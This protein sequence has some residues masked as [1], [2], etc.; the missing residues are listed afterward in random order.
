M[1]SMEKSRLDKKILLELIKDS[2]QSL[3][4]IARKAGTTRQTVA[5]KIKQLKES[6]AVGPP[7]PRLD[8]EKFGLTT[9]A[10]IFL[11]EDPRGEL[12]KKDEEAIKKFYQ[13]SEFYRLFGRYSAVLEVWVKDSKELTSLVKRIHKLKGVR[14]TETFIVHSTVKNE[15]EAPFVGILKSR[16]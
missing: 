3:S 1:L 12:R 6:E 4:E 8:P 7:T 14:E 13:V 2:E 11:R 5:K 16:G 9:K 15:P 10:Y